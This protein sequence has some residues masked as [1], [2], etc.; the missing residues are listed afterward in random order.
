MAPPHAAPGPGAPAAP[1]PGA[2]TPAVLDERAR[3][4]G[5]GTVDRPAA[6]DGERPTVLVVEDEE[7]LAELYEEWLR[8]EYDVEVAIGGEAAVEAMHDGVDVVTLDRR[9]PGTTGDEVLETI[10]AEGY[11]AAVVMVTAVEPDV[12][13]V[14]LPIDDYVT[15]PITGET[16]LDVV[17]RMVQLGDLP[18]AVRRYHSLERRRDVLRTASSLTGV[19]TTE[20]YQQL[21]TRLESAAREAGPGLAWLE[22][23]YYG[24]E[25]SGTHD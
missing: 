9:M 19:T 20:E 15:K 17:E 11:D 3:T 22:E 12:D 24:S 8:D 2:R 6:T 18:S 14:E 25:E 7:H 5:G 16:F 21:T 1:D 10:R 4:D 23:D 13:L